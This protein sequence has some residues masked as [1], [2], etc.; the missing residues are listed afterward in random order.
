M[1]VFREEYA[2]LEKKKRRE[3]IIGT[4]DKDCGEKRNGFVRKNKAVPFI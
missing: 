2:S 3:D 4:E 1:G